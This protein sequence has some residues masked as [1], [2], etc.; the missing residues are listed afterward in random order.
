MPKVTID[1]PSGLI[2]EMSKRFTTGELNRNEG[3]VSDC[4][5]NVDFLLAQLFHPY[6]E[7]H[8]TRQ[9]ALRQNGKTKDGAPRLEFIEVDDFDA[10]KPVLNLELSP[11]LNKQARALAALWGESVE[12][13]ATK[14]LVA[15]VA[16]DRDE[17]VGQGAES[18]PEERG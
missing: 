15:V 17:L 3:L 12:K 5:I 1:V 14:A 7:R 10:D 2:D 4:K 8:G 18:V 11:K 13:F 9:I 6:T 16:A